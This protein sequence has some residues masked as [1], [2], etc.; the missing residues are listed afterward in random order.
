[1]PARDEIREILLITN[2]TSGRGRARAWAEAALARLEREGRP[3]RIVSARDVEPASLAASVAESWLFGGDGTLNELL[4]QLDDKA[5][6]ISIFPTGTGNVVARELAIPRTLHGALENARRGTEHPFDLGRINGRRFAFM[7]SV[8]L[9]A[10][11]VRTVSRSRKGP[12]KRCDWVFAG[13]ACRRCEEPPF[14]IALD[15]GAPEE[16]RYVAIFNCGLY[17]GG[18]RVCPAARWNDG[19]FHVLTLDAPILPRWARVAF[20]AWRGR[21]ERLEGASLRTARR[22]VISGAPRSQVDGDP[23]PGGELVVEIEPSAVRL[24]G[25]A[26]AGREG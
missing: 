2:P 11:L 6:P 12:M 17:A 13:I 14:K 3:A 4:Q 5:P 21:P 10:E 19:L 15:G 16:A 8:G 1:M 9:D 26:G 20:A 22:V 23:G 25:A 7:V 24:R 18:F